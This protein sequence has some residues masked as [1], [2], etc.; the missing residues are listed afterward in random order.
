MASLALAVVLLAGC[1]GTPPGVITVDETRLLVSDAPTP[2]PADLPGWQAQ[3]LPDVWTM[4]RRRRA[5]EGWYRARIDLPH[6]PAE[7]WAVYLPR[8]AMNAAVFVNGEL[9]G[10]GGP[11]TQPLPRNWNRPQLYTVPSGLLHAGPNVV[12]VHLAVNRSAPGMLLPF[13]V[14]PDRLLRPEWQT[15]YFLQ[16]TLTQVIAIMT[17]GV[18]LLLLGFFAN[19]DP[20]G[21]VR[22]LALGILLWAISGADA[23]V[24]ISPIPTRAWEWMQA[25]SQLG[26]VVCAMIAFHRVLAVD[27]RRFE[28]WAG[29]GVATLGVL[30]A[31]VPDVF[32]YTFVVLA[33]GATV[34][35]GGYVLV[36]MASAPREGRFQRARRMLIP[37]LV[38]VFLGLHDVLSVLAGRMLLGVLLAPYIPSLLMLTTAWSV[39]RYLGDALTQSETLN[40]EL[41]ERVRARGA[42]LERNYERLRELERERAVAGERDRIMRDMH[43]G[44]GGQLVSTLA[45]VESGAA[46][47]DGIAEAIRD[48]LDDL[49]LVIDSLDPVEEDLLTVLGMIRARLEPRLLRHGLRFDWQVADLPRIPGFGPERV[50]Q[51]LR[52]VQEAITNVLK[53]ARARTIVVQTGHETDGDGRPGVFVEVRDD[54]CGMNGARPSGRGLANMRRRAALLGGRVALATG[55]RGTAVRLWLPLEEATAA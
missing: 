14:G 40:R 35:L 29:L 17:F 45:L 53:H 42:E 41:E 52:I 27:R 37:G 12:D 11:F 21:I 31:I 15:R 16:V 36:V 1:G 43:D 50:L 10:D 20:G 26:F 9:V 28:R 48:A 2:P 33:G 22:W 25:M 4:W 30:L 6:E 23:F 7:L 54:G 34:V 19:R 3:R 5:V 55:T 46:S 8:V 24:R 32:A 38:G 18:A 51:A 13:Q 44:M 47:A 49:R 39:L